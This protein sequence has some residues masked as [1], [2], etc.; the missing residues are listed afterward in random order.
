MDYTEFKISFKKIAPINDVVKS[1]LNEIGF[2][3]FVDAYFDRSGNI[4]NIPIDLANHLCE[5]FTSTGGIEDIDK[6][7][8]RFKAFEAAGQTQLSLRLHDDPMHALDLI[9]EK[10]I[11]HFK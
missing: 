10:V 1:V 11:P 8:E 2:E 6:E 7:I 9:G 5:V 3:S 4:K